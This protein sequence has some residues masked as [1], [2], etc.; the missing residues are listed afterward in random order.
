MTTDI[1]CRRCDCILSKYGEVWVDGWDI[2]ECNYSDNH[3]PVE[4]ESDD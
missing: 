4:V 1:R 3:D 2:A